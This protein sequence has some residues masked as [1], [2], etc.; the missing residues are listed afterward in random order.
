[1]ENKNERE[2]FVY[3][4]ESCRNEFKDGET[5]LDVWVLHGEDN[6]HVLGKGNDQESAVVNTLE[7]IVH[8]EQYYYGAIKTSRISSEGDFLAV[9]EVGQGQ[10]KTVG[11]SEGKDKIINSIKAYL[12]GVNM[13]NKIKYGKDLSL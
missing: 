6:I 9:A 13:I 11:R 7:K 5:S 3:E 4:L 2:Y 12:D 10:L 8:K 1:M